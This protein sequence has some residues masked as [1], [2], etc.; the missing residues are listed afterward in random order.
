MVGHLKAAN[1]QV[2]LSNPSLLHDLINKLP[3]NIRLDW[4]L[5]KKQMVVAGLETFSNYMSAIISAA[6]DVAHYS[7]FEAS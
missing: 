4:A 1:Q 5:Y 2:H 3:A 6:S 7:D